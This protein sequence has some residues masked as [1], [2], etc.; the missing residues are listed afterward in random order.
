MSIDPMEH[1]INELEDGENM[2]EGDM[3]GTI[4]PSDQWT[5]KRNDMALQMY[6]EWIANRHH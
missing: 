5:A 1:E 4:G 3:L 2:V 6:N